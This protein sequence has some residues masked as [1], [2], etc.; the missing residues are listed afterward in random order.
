M[1]CENCGDNE[2]V[3]F[4]TNPACSKLE[5]SNVKLYDEWALEYCQGSKLL[6]PFCKGYCSALTQ[7]GTPSQSLQYRTRK[8]EPALTKFCKYRVPTKDDPSAKYQSVCGCYFPQEVY[9][10]FADK[11]KKSLAG[12]EGL[13]DT[14]RNCLFPACGNI[15]AGTKKE[16]GIPWLEYKQCKP[17]NIASCTQD[18]GVD[19]TAAH[20]E[21]D[22]TL[23]NECNID[24]GGTKTEDSSNDNKEDSSNDNKEEKKEETSTGGCWIL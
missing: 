4:Q 15:V 10:D 24:F 22:I 9:D 13:V 11:M 6:T 14:Q 17:T 20:M 8:C 19:M 7:N 21:G 12:M 23:K 18:A 1:R 16:H 3:G 2:T 5:Q